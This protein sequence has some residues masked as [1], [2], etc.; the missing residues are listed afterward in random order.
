M[1]NELGTKSDYEKEYKEMPVAKLVR[2][3]VGLDRQAAVE[4]FSE[5]LNDE[6]LNSNQIHFVNLIVDYVVKNGLIDDNR[7]L[8][9]DP[10]RT[11]GSI[12]TL[13]ENKVDERN[14]LL[15]VIKCIKE[16]AEQIV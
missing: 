15:K 8:M 12:V 10:F 11:I 4:A 13:F 1:W 14:K 5:F 16:N 9:E 3:I 6:S 2:K 7:V